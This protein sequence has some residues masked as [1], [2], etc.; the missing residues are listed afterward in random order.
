MMPAP[1]QRVLLGFNFEDFLAIVGPGAL[2]R[3]VAISR[4]HWRDWRPGQWRAYAAALPR[5]ERLADIGEVDGG[6]FSAEAAIAARPDLAI[7]AAWQFRALG[8]TVERLERAVRRASAIA[9]SRAA[10]APGVSSSATRRLRII[11]WAL[12]GGA[13]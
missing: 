6:T 11:G 2:D 4:G 13:V 5:L 3:V 7:L 9:A 10:R 8:P 12:R 1:A